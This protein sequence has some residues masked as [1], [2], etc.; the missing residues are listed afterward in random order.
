[1]NRAVSVGRPALDDVTGV[2]GEHE[3]T[4]DRHLG[5]TMAE[6]L[7]LDLLGRIEH[8][9]PIEQHVRRDGG[10]QQRLVAR[11][12]DGSAGRQRVG[13]RSSRSGDDQAVGGE[14]RERLAVDAGEQ[15]D[16]VP[17]GVLLDDD[18]VERS[19]PPEFVVRRA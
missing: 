12:H 5:A 6:H 14:A 18:L 17:G 4:V 1:M 3:S 7:D 2:D 11:R 8:E 9:R 10:E 19:P 16:G 13:G 15:A